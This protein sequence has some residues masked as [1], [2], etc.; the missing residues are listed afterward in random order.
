MWRR[1]GVYVEF[2]GAGGVRSSRQACRSACDVGQVAWRPVRLSPRRS[3]MHVWTRSITQLKTSRRQTTQ[4]LLS[5]AQHTIYVPIQVTTR[6]AFPS[7]H[8]AR[9]PKSSASQPSHDDSMIDSLPIS[10]SLEFLS[11]ALPT[12]LWLLRS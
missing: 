2:G 9:L 7:H 8:L 3:L 12:T 5:E 4:T 10:T 6:R 11:M 1:G